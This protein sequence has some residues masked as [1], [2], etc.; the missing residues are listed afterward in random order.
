LIREMVRE[1]FYNGRIDDEHLD[2][3]MPRFSGENYVLGLS[4]VIGV[5]RKNVELEKVAGTPSFIAV[6]SEDVACPPKSQELL[7]GALNHY[8][9]R[10]PY[11]S[12]GVHKGLLLRGASHNDLIHN[13][14]SRSSKDYV[15]SV[16]RRA[17]SFVSSSFFLGF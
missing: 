12:R 7:L 3:L 6:G 1:E 10:N 17:L 14:I 4:S 2:W 16:A 13:R 11:I 8:S 5:F 15:K 9:L